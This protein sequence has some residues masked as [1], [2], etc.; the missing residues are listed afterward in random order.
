MKFSKST[1]LA[2]HGLWIL[3]QNRPQQVFIAEL[4]LK[5]NVSQTY[6]AKVFQK[7]A[8]KGLVNSVRGKRGGFCLARDPEGISIA[9]VARAVEAEEPFF[10]CLAPVRGCEG[11]NDC[12]VR[13]TFLH[14][15]EV[16]YEVLEKITLADLLLVAQ[17]NGRS[18]W[19]R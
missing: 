18:K 15:G 3:A 9:D 2:V 17:N 4:A 13:E 1:D 14:A 7:L 10:E 6:L 11:Q 19:L 5:Q 16:M 12:K 8:R